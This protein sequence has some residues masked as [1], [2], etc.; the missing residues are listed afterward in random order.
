MFQSQNNAELPN[1]ERKE[2][3][4]GRIINGDHNGYSSNVDRGYG[5]G[6]HV[7]GHNN[8][9][10]SNIGINHPSRI[11][12]EGDNNG[13]IENSTRFRMCRLL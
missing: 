5:H 11:R 3:V 9:Y 6:T 4:G 1:N 13:T 12:V 7:T 10:L 2:T 8:G